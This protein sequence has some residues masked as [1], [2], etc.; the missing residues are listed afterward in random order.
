MKNPVGA[1]N[2]SGIFQKLLSFKCF[3]SESLLQIQQALR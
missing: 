1:F 2:V 3:W